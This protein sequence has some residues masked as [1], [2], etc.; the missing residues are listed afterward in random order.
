MGRVG[1]GIPIVSRVDMQSFDWICPPTDMD[2]KERDRICN[3]FDADSRDG[4]DVHNMTH[5]TQIWCTGF[6]GKKYLTTLVDAKI[7]QT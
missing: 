4:N 6:N 1:F 3:A 7:H 5:P 2:K